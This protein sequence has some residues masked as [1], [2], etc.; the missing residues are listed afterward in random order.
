MGYTEETIAIQNLF[1]TEWD[2]ATAIS[3]E[4]VPFTPPENASWVEITIIPGKSKQTLGSSPLYRHHGI[5]DVTINIPVNTA[6]TTALTLLD[7]A[8]TIFR[9]AQVSGITFRSSYRNKGYD[10]DKWHKINL[11]IPYYRE[12]R[13]S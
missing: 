4:N 6:Q 11:T 12:E 5:I 2:S 7:N 13:F 1:A 10:V 8:A 3:Y 9:N